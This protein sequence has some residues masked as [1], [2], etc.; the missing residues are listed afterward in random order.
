MTYGIAYNNAACNSLKNNWCVYY[1]L[2]A[3]Q[4][5]YLRCIFSYNVIII[6][7]ELNLKFDTY[8]S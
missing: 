8:V 7:I 1:W 2:K 3:T 4:N 5:V 6:Y